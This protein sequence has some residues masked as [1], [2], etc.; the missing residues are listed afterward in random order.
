MDEKRIAMPE[1]DLEKASE[2]LTSSL[3]ETS[4]Q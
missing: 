2:I 3:D 4:D 1:K